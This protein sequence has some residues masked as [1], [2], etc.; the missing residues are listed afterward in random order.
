MIGLLHHSWRSFLRNAQRYRTLL[1]A[2]IVVIAAV[3]FVLSTLLGM[4]D[5]IREKASRYFAGDVVVLGY[6]GTGD[7]VIENPD[8]VLN[9]LGEATATG[10]GSHEAIS[11]R[12]TYYDPRNT[13]LF[14]AG[15]WTQQRRLIGVEWE[16]ERPIL[17]GFDFVSGGV[18]EN[19]DD[20]KL[21]ISSATASALHADTGDSLIVSI[22]SDRGRSNTV[23]LEIGGVYR[24]ASFFG[25]TTYL[26]RTVLNRL[27]EVPESRVNEIGVYLRQRGTQHIE[28]AKAITEAIDKQLPTFPVLTTREAY[29]DEPYAPRDETHYGTVTLNAQLSE[30]NDL[31]GAL[32][33]IAGAIMVLFLGILVIG[34]SNTFSM[35]VYERTRE[36]GT[37]R[38]LGMSRS[39]TIAWFLLESGFLGISG[40]L[41][42]LAVGMGVLASVRFF[43][44]FPENTWSTLFFVG[45]RLSYTVSIA[46]VGVITV[47]A[48]AASVFGALRSAFRAGNVPPVE[49]IG[50]EK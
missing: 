9:A 12:S 48:L 24:E 40:V 19:G 13:G 25:Y 35:I 43:L 20:G 38:A 4:R 5:S 30:I 6:N 33:M 46:S 1:L 15:Y 22:I 47:L 3:F 14:F 18:P 2:L 23:E 27:K 39:K 34:V 42:G 37:L 44:V 7:S 31:I 10:T 17:E 26:S 29:Q 49:A 32:T 28:A 36:I 21:L 16:R 8:Q 50:H 45:G 41:L 11:V